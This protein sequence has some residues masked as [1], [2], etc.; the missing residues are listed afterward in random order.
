MGLQLSIVSPMSHSRLF[1]G[2]YKRMMFSMRARRLTGRRIHT[3]KEYQFLYSAELL[4]L[5]ERDGFEKHDR[6][7]NVR[8]AT[9]H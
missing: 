4:K 8:T 1:G 7:D 6:I 3:Q 9:G 2:M 5:D